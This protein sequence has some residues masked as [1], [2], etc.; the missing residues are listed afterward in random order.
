MLK[1]ELTLKLREYLTDKEKFD[2]SKIN[3]NI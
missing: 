1:S 2:N 3:C